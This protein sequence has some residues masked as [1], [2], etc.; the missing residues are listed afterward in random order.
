MLFR[1]A[2]SPS[3]LL[4]SFHFLPHGTKIPASWADAYR[5][6]KHLILE[7]RPD[8]TQT[9]IREYQD[10]F[11]LRD[12]LSADLA[13]SLTNACSRLNLSIELLQSHYPWSVGMHL[14]SRLHLQSGRNQPGIDAILFRRAN[15]AGKPI[16]T[17]ESINDGIGSFPK[18]DEL[19][20]IDSLRYVVSDVDARLRQ[21][22]ELYNSWVAESPDGMLAAIPEIDLFP[23]FKQKVLLDRNITWLPSVINAI[24][25]QTP[26]L[27]VVGVL[28]LIG[29]GSL[30]E[31]LKS[32]GFTL[33]H[34]PR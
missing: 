14:G 5:K 34:I 20:T 27:I 12:H 26:S 30:L 19:Q 16:A 3:Y 23:D 25:S 33:T 7:A 8:E 9:V 17:L 10:G 2:G 28:H 15:D 32:E 1:I 13:Q 11:R 24:R 4:G 31:L 18:V 21:A 22:T 29:S 6:T